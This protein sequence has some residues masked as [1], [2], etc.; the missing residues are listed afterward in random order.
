MP[1]L[2]WNDSLRLGVETIDNEHQE[3]LAILNNVLE[4]KSK[5]KTA[6]EGAE[7]IDRLLEF[8]IAHFRHEEELMVRIGYPEFESHRRAHVKLREQ[9]RFL[10]K[11]LDGED[12]PALVRL[13]LAGF[14]SEWLADHLVQMDLPMAPH[15]ARHVALNGPL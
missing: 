8:S 15:I 3:L 4:A 5:P 11:V 1:F 10:K 13:E 2:T 14:L 9:A 12:N 6:R 7:L